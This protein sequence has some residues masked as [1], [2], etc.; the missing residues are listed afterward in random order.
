MSVYVCVWNCEYVLFFFC[1]GCPEFHP[2]WSLSTSHL[3]NVIIGLCH[4]IT[5]VR[6]VINH[7]L[8]TV[9]G[10]VGISLRANW[11]GHPILPHKKK[12]N[13]VSTLIFESTDRWRIRFNGYHST[14]WLFK[15]QKSNPSRTQPSQW[16]FHSTLSTQIIWMQNNTTHFNLPIHEKTQPNRDSDAWM[17]PNIQ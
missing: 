10:A 12:K 14:H 5:T 1:C 16:S 13:I 6:K 3:C 11:P 17:Y 8:R 2:A 4:E 9:V 7:C 15:L